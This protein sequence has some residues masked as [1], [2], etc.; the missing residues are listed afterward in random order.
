M[1]GNFWEEYDASP[2][3]IISPRILIPLVV[4]GVIIIIIS[5]FLEYYFRNRDYLKLMDNQA[6]LFVTSLANTGQSS[7]Q[8]ADALETEVQNSMLANLQL[9]SA[10]HENTPFT[11]KSL[12]EK[13][14][15]GRFDRLDIYL[16]SGE[17]AVS[18]SVPAAAESPVPRDIL[19]AVNNGVLDEIMLTGSDSSGTDSNIFT[20]MV[21]RRGGGAVVGVVS[22]S[23][24]QSFRNLYSFGRL[25]REFEKAPEVEYVVL[26]S[27]ETIIAGIFGD[28]KISR[29][30][31]DMFLR[32]TFAGN[33]VHTREVYYNDIPIYEAAVSFSGNDEPIGL[34]RLGLSMKNYIEMKEKFKKGM[35]AAGILLMVLSVTLLSFYLSYRNRQL[36]REGFIRLQ[37]YT[38]HILEN[39]ASG[40]IAVEETGTV[41]LANKRAGIILNR[42]KD[43][44]VG[45]SIDVLPEEIRR[46]YK[47][48]I[49]QKKE[50]HNPYYF[51]NKYNGTVRQISLRT[52][53]L[54]KGTDI[55]NCILLLDDTT[56]QARMA[57]Q[58]RRQEKLSAMG[59]LASRV[60]H[61]IR[62]PLNS[63]GLIVQNLVR[64]IS[65]SGEPD[66]YSENLSIVEKEI[67]RINDIVDEFI[68][69]ARPAEIH[70]ELIDGDDFFSDI[71]NL[72]Q[73]KCEKRQIDLTIDIAKNAK[74]FGDKDQLKQVFINLIENSIQ[75]I[76]PPGKIKISGSILDDHFEMRVSDTGSGI[77][78]ENIPY[79]FDLYYTTKKTG[80]G[81]G[82]S[83]VHQI[84][85]GHGGSIDINS[86]TEKGTTFIIRLPN[87]EQE[88]YDETI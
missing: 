62:N 67:Y 13:M 40:V 85:T 52:T 65:R 88:R 75:S 3:G 33:E 8:A 51:W 12:R 11:K 64:K 78:K 20:A 72:F 21:H 6:R 37:Q 82:L 15:Q 30:S 61:E 59:R 49:S 81:I 73:S 22:N 86:E 76:S 26:Q 80:T 1:S 41:L 17:I 54:M 69:F 63:M 43:D 46:M 19:A 66:N 56:E 28:Y 36:L 47:R 44:I 9:I 39:M 77:P 42:N 18:V 25:F 32:N 60:A 71:K 27:P 70:R 45:Y 48:C 58:L 23:N 16:K 55:E 31:E 5:G 29:F 53:L 79:I 7:L 10:L 4:A 38:N 74:I 14:R 83:V 68:K 87:R 57:E 35:V 50:I 84:I 34:L 2:R 24:I